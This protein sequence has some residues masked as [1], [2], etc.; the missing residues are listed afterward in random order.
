MSMT[1]E[2]VIIAVLVDYYWQTSPQPT[3]QG[4]GIFVN[5]VMNHLRGLGVIPRGR[6]AASQCSALWVENASLLQQQLREALVGSARRWSISTS[7]QLGLIQ[8]LRTRR[9]RSRRP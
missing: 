5:Y 3:R 6:E 9:A 1:L 8:E 4:A 2:E 7:A